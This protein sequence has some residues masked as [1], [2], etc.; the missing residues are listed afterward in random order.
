MSTGTNGSG[1]ELARRS[2][3]DLA[4][5]AMS[6]G[7]AVER[8]NALVAFVKQIMVDGVD[9]GKIPGTDK[10]TLLKAGA[11]KLV[12]FFGLSVQFE[13]VR[14]IEDW[15]GAEHG[16]EALFYY[17]YRCKMSRNGHVI[18]ES[19][20]SCNSRDAKYRWRWVS[21]RDLPPST[22]KTKMVQ[23]SGSVREFDFAIRKRETSGKWG[24]PDAYWDR[25]ERAIADK[26]ARQITVDLKGKPAIQWE[27]GDTVYRV[28]N[29]DVAGLINTIQKMSQKRALVG[30][31]LLAVNAS[32]YFTQDVEDMVEIDMPAS[33][34]T[35]TQPIQ[36]DY[37]TDENGEPVL[38]HTPTFLS[39]WDRA[40]AARPVRINSATGAN[41]IAALMEK[42]DHKANS[43]TAA[44]RAEK[45]EQLH[46]GT[47]DAFLS[48]KTAS[49]EVVQ[50]SHGTTPG[51][52]DGG[53][54]HNGTDRT[55]QKPV[56]KDE[57]VDAEYSQPDPTRND[58]IDVDR[59][60]REMQ[61]VLPQASPGDVKG[62]V[63]AYAERMKKKTADDLTPDARLRIW[64]AAREGRFVIPGGNILAPQTAAAGA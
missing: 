46:A 11:E 30:T 33:R 1:T 8:R 57:V 48:P 38:E 15:S 53:D 10:N 37:Q 51:T 36:H 7:E 47:F 40:I 32:E 31:A 59:F 29:E 34:T 41:F 12:T 5:P 61:R 43:H 39:E 56:K 4:M 63:L 26:T 2:T 19:D 45:L 62:A 42:P 58:M 54:A 9:F 35:V 52:V 21:E 28:P 64:Q 49:Q 50:P 27:I 60:F 13:L 24:K 23:K 18:A 25:F 6:I 20:A 22:D 55:R 14:C 44:W 16:G 17:V 3:Q